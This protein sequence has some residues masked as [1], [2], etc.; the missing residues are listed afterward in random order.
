MGFWLGSIKQWDSRDAHSKRFLHAAFPSSLHRRRRSIFGRQSRLWP[1]HHIALQCRQLAGSLRQMDAFGK[2]WQ[3]SRGD[4]FREAMIIS[5]LM[6]GLGNQMFEYA[7][8]LSLA[9]R[10][11][12]VL[13]ID[14]SYF[15]EGNAD[16][17]TYAL[18][19]LSVPAQF[20]SAEEVASFTMRPTGQE[21]V[22]A[23]LCSL[24]GLRRWSDSLS[25]K[26]R[27][28]YQKQWTYYPEF[29]ELPDNTWLHGN[30]QSE[31]FFAPHADLIRQQFTFRYP[32]TAAV[33]AVARKVESGPSVAVHFRL[34]DYASNPRFASGNGVLSKSYYESALESLQSRLGSDTKFY[35]FSDEPQVASRAFG[36]IKVAGEWVTC[37][38]AANHHDSMRLMALC[39]HNIIANSSFSWWAAWLNANPHK[40]VIAP[41]QWYADDHNPTDDLLP[42]GWERV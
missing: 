41:K 15:R 32:P 7:A 2:E 13:K 27:P 23:K 1:W 39:D 3:C 4:T 21:R 10:R 19:C 28:H 40:I 31:K 30:Y 42:E 29:H 38:G 36:D 34:G 20:A 14:P 22:M 17:R 6:G 18:D 9:M 33:E 37:C 26:G 24:V 8:G 5:H 25:M 35:F 16:G 12:A 11:N